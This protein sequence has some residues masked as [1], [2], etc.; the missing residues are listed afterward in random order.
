MLLDPPLQTALIACALAIGAC[1]LLSLVTREYSWVDRLWSVMPPLYVAWFALAAGAADLRLWAMALLVGLWG[2]RLTFNFARKGGYSRGGEDYRW[3]ELRSRMSPLG[4]QLFN[5]FFVA[6]F[7]H[8]LLLAISL[9]ALSALREARRPFG[10]VD[11]LLCAL[12]LLLLAG[13]TL[14]DEQQW[15]FQSDKRARRARGERVEHEFL[16]SG[17]FRYSRHPNFFFEQ[18]QW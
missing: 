17:L 18:A 10:G 8:L 2:A 16:T 13:E 11:A 6:L 7:Q 1:W 9:P 12:F 4:F 14:A 3:A 15:R 5:F